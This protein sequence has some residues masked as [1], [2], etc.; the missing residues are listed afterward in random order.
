MGYVV[1]VSRAAAAEISSV[2]VGRSGGKREEA[3]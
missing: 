1:T 3:W 2:A